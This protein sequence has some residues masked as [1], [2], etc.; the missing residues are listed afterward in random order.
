MRALGYLN[1]NFYGL[2]PWIWLAGLVLLFAAL[3]MIGW[4]L[5]GRLLARKGYVFS[6][7]GT[8]RRLL[9]ESSSDPMLLVSRR[10]RI[11]EANQ[12]ACDLAG[13]TQKELL[14]QPLEI[15]VSPGDAP[16]VRDARR[17]LSAARTVTENVLLQTK[18]Q[19]MIRTEWRWVSASRNK[20]YIIMRDLRAPTRLEAPPELA[21]ELTALHR[22]SLA[23]TQLVH[24]ESVLQHAISESMNV[25]GADVGLIC[26]INREQRRV[27][28]AA[29]EALPAERLR[30]AV[31]SVPLDGH[32][33][34]RH[35]M[36]TPE[37]LYYRS[38]YRAPLPPGMLAVLQEQDVHALIV[39]PIVSKG[40]VL[41]QL[42]LGVRRP[43]E[44][45]SV[46]TAVLTAI[47]EQVG[48]AIE[49]ARLIEQVTEKAIHLEH[50][51]DAGP[52]AILVVDYLPEG[53]IVTL[54]NQRFCRMFGLSP[55]NV[56]QKPFEQVAA[57][58]AAGF[59]READF[60]RRWARL[61]S[62]RELEGRGELKLAGP[63][64][65]VVDH[66]TGPVFD[67][68]KQIIG[69]IWVFTDITEQK[70]LAEGLRQAQKLESIGTLAAGIAHDFKN[71]LGAIRGNAVLVRDHLGGNRAALQT[72]AN[73][74]LAV[75]SGV[76]MCQ[77]LLAFGRK[78]PTQL[79]PMRVG[80]V[81]SRA[82]RLLRSSLPANIR[83]ETDLADDA[84]PVEAD[85]T[86]LLQAVM[87][88]AINARDAMPDGGSLTFR[89]ATRTLDEEAASSQVE[90][91][92]GRFTVL[93][94]EDTGQG[95][96]PELLPRIFEPFFTT[97]PPGKGTGLGLSMVYGIAKSHNGWVAVESRVGAGTKFEIFLPVTSAEVK[98]QTSEVREQESETG[99]AGNGGL[100]PP[101]FAAA[102]GQ[103]VLLADDDPMLLDLTKT[104]LERDGCKVLAARSGQEALELYRTRAGEVALAILDMTMPGMSGPECLQQIRAIKPDAR[105]MFLT[106]HS[107]DVACEE[108]GRLGAVAVLTKPIERRILLE[109]VRRA[110]TEITGGRP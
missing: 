44:F 48:M 49:N 22:V 4:R 16:A 36:Q 54:A 6:P 13:W 97:K 20:F 38:L 40:R 102:G 28:L 106:G 91:R 68:F 53:E 110:W 105:A 42:E 96:A 79:A 35:L 69:R 51:L 73:I 33:L 101:G 62:D 30:E 24:I 74:E 57:S 99:A 87:N 3:F 65:R 21:Q 82:A 9:M 15:L 108:A 25:V 77:G 75:D 100:K 64:P 88:L 14:G 94:V 37:I 86:Q 98:S 104:F 10:G 72:L 39:I 78:A 45:F 93:T 71:L 56:L 18:A 95:I 8:W 76:D 26:F 27:T 60:E 29:Q 67:E 85:A 84:Q 80:E 7:R 83:L 103:T 70:T 43:H 89:V 92:P 19:E 59:D 1:A 12:H 90:A 109:E 46:N 61:R 107:A 5:C 55:S 63:K 2:P 47:G 11:L 41:G 52:A 58:L 50:V 31:E 32:W 66:Y 34:S 81:V 17:R 23:V